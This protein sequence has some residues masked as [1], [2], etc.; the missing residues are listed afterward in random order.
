MNLNISSPQDQSRNIVVQQL[1]TELEIGD[2]QRLLNED[3]IDF[4]VLKGP[5]LGNTVYPDSL[6]RIYEDLD[7]LVRP[8]QHIAALAILSSHGYRTVDPEP[9]RLETARISYHVQLRSPRGLLVELH[10]HLSRFDR[11]PVDIE[12]L[13]AR[14]VPFR[15]GGVTAHGLC[16]SHLIVQLVIHVLKSYFIVD[17][18]HFLDIALVTR[19]ELLDWD[20]IVDLLE[21]SGAAGGGFYVLM[22]ACKLS[23][24]IVPDEVLERLRPRLIRRAWLDRYITVGTFPI[25]SSEGHSRSETQFRLALPLMDRL[26]SWPVIVWKYA[27]VRFLDYFWLLRSKK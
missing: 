27:T 8:E 20:Y 4:L 6:D 13:F 16:P 14:S 2:L 23:N 5:H 17:Y 11:Y 3:G 25:Y 24:A 1:L 7:I 26:W 19:V 21:L 10:R 22:A 9:N 15:I 18:K 12:Q